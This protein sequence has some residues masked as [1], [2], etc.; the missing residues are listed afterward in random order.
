MAD[1]TMRSPTGAR[2]LAFGLWLGLLYGFIEGAEALALSVIPGALSWRTGNSAHVLWVAPLVYG[3]VFA[4]LALPFALLSRV[5]RRVPWDTALVFALVL[6]GGFLAASLQ[7]QLFSTLASA[8]LGLGVATELTRQYRRHRARLAPLMTRTIPHMLGAVAVAAL[9]VWG[10]GRA[11][12]A[13]GM[14][15]LGA[16]APGTPNV[17][18]LVMDTQRADHLSAYGYA[19]P[20]SPRLSR[21]A[22]EGM[23][24]ENA[25]ANS[26]WTLPSHASLMTGRY[27]REHRAGEMRRPWLDDR[28]PTLAEALRA[29]GYAT[30]G[31]VANTY[32]CGRQT[33]LDRG[34]VRY[35]DFYGN[36]GDAVARTV[37][38]RR[39]AYELLPRFGI[40]DVPGR[41][42]ATEINGD[43]LDWVDG[44][45]RRP[46]F[47]FV[48]YFDVHG[49]LF[50]PAPYAGRF[51]AGDVQ[52]RKAKEIE[53]GALTPEMQLPP[54]EEIRRMRD[55]YDESILYLDSQIGAL[56]DALD[57]RGLL[58]NTLVIVTSD[59]GESWGEHGMLYHGHSL[60]REQT[61]VP[62]ILRLPGVVPAGVR[63]TRAV[64]LH[65]LPATVAEIVGADAQLF[66]GRSLLEPGDDAQRPALTQVSRRSLVP[67]FW[68]TSRTALS[69]LVTER[70]HLIQPDSGAAELYDLSNDPGELRDLATSPEGAAL[71]SQLRS[72][73]QA[74]TTAPSLARGN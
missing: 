74:V 56:L 61:H 28:F 42:W 33:R 58:R 66:P 55:A 24:F 52:A 10:A 60:Y 21:M 14:R 39:I 35:E 49:P 7:G 48:N 11:R 37:L 38:G 2:L 5:A 45:D 68:P 36:V 62:L 3:A 20:T 13:W 22:A 64:G 17:L 59:H 15:G 9:L 19:R 31:F 73:M 46:F 16:A 23:I 50:P 18:L 29:R 57:R 34:F 40:N 1:A 26:S 53:I 71:L 63:D 32:W 6:T 44:L 69:A 30:G 43:V 51:S 41:K 67:S 4:V 8:L 54:A 47:A 27:P 72:Q 70:W 12:E 25:S 65:Q